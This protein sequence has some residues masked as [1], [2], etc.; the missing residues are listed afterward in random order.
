MNLECLLFPG[1]EMRNWKRKLEENRGGERREVLACSVY[2]AVL[3]APPAENG[4]RFSG[5]HLENPPPARS[6]SEREATGAELPGRASFRYLAP[7]LAIWG[8]LSVR[9]LLVVLWY[10]VRSSAL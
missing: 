5:W 2:F 9:Y 10:L 7:D 8:E 6:A 3:A 4:G 1:N